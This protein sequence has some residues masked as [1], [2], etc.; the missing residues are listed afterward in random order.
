MLRCRRKRRI[1]V[2]LS[3]Q[4]LLTTLLSTFTI[5]TTTKSSTLLVDLERFDCAREMKKVAGC[6]DM[7][8]HS[9]VAIPA[10]NLLLY[11]ISIKKNRRYGKFDKGFPLTRNS[12]VWHREYGTIEGNTVELYCGETKHEK[13]SSQNLKT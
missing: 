2:V 13:P 3:H 4:L 11:Q 9:L 12:L 5:A 8:N 1:L 7:V 10:S 6:N